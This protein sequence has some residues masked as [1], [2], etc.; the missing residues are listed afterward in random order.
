M[1]FKLVFAIILVGK[2]Q[3]ISF[4]PA[5]TSLNKAEVALWIN[6]AIADNDTGLPIVTSLTHY[7]V[8]LSI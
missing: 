1:H 3:Q 5:Q 4:F 6:A 8:L 2:T 7:T